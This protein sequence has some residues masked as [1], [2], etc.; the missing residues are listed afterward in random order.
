MQSVLDLFSI[1]LVVVTLLLL[2]GCGQALVRYARQPRRQARATRLDRPADIDLVEAAELG[3]GRRR[4]LEATLVDLVVRR[5]V[6][7]VRETDG[8][9]QLELRDLQGLTSLELRLVHIVFGLRADVGARRTVPT[10]S[11]PSRQRWAL[12][13]KRLKAAARRQ[14]ETRALVERH[15]LPFDT[16]PVFAT[17]IVVLFSL[18]C[19]FFGTVVGGPRPIFLVTTIYAVGAL[20]VLVVVA[21]LTEQTLAAAGG[22]ARDQLWV[23]RDFVRASRGHRR[24]PAQIPSADFA[25]VLP[26]A[27]LW[28]RE[29]EWVRAYS[30][31][32]GTVPDWW[33]DS[34]D[35]FE[36]SL[37]AVVAA[38]E[39]DTNMGGGHD[40]FEVGDPADRATG[41]IAGSL[42]GDRAVVDN[43][44]IDGGTDGS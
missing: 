16:L 20:A 39:A 30:T 13:E 34:L 32:R 19:G 4:G 41:S 12:A 24:T 25:A 21:R 11:G 7:I 27:V 1:A 8:R 9:Y 17:A 18:F 6:R 10:R 15:R 3:R 22:D 37:A 33:F 28:G 14:L 35:S 44:W 29:T 40:G 2:L 23:L 38:L 26:Y 42:R 43:G 31:H 5:R 36:T